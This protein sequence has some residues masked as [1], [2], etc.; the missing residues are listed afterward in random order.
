MEYSHDKIR[1]DCKRHFDTLKFSFQTL[2]MLFT[3]LIKREK[4]K[5]KIHETFIYFLRFQDMVL[6]FDLL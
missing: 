2:F 5:Y 4:T 6:K 1:V 3:L